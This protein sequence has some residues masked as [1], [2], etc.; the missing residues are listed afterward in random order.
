M[1]TTLAVENAKE[2][3]G[4]HPEDVVSSINSAANVVSFP[5]Q[6]KISPTN[7]EIKNHDA[8]V[9]LFNGILKLLEPKI[10]QAISEMISNM[11]M[12][13]TEVHHG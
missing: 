9:D 12:R 1:K 10:H 2:L 4:E 7:D 6:R 8:A 11:V 13:K 5:R 3:F